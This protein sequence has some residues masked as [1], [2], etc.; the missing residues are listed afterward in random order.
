MSSKIWRHATDLQ[1]KEASIGSFR[2]LH[3]FGLLEL[4]DHCARQNGV[5]IDAVDIARQ[6]T[7]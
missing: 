1:S 5:D 2:L 4:N 6:S 3:V 7:H